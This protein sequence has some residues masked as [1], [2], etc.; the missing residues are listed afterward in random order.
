VPGFEFFR[1][2]ALGYVPRTAGAALKAIATGLLSASHFIYASAS[3][4]PLDEEPFDLD[5]IERVLARTDLSLE[6]DLLL[7][8]VFEKLIRSGEQEIALFGAEGVNALEDRRTARIR[9]LTERDAGAE[10]QRAL[11]RQY[12]EMAELQ[13]DAGAVRAFY[14]REAYAAVVKARREG[15]VMRTDLALTIDILVSLGLHSQ[16][17]ALLARVRPPEHPFILLLSARVAFHRGRYARVSECCRKLA[18]SAADLDEEERGLVEFWTT[19]GE[20]G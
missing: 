4:K 13:G 3:A 15:R 5:A 1:H 12:F 14:L 11:A 7:K 16:A 17:A 8:A 9:Q 10:E 19:G 6:T 2:R 18:A 20:R